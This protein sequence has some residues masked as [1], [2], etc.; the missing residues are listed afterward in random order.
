MALLEREKVRPPGARKAAILMLALGPED[1][2]ELLAGLDPAEVEEISSEMT[3]LK[4]APAELRTSVLN[5]F[6]SEVEATRYVPEP[7]LSYLRRLLERSLG[8]EDARAALDRVEE[9]LSR[10][11]FRFLHEADPATIVNLLREEH[12]QTCALILCHLPPE[13]AAKC[14]EGLPEEKRVEV[15]ARAGRMQPTSHEAVRNVEKAVASRLKLASE[16]RVEESGGPEAVARILNRAHRAVGSQVM[17]SLEE[18]D[19]EL[20]GRLK[21]MMFRFEDII[22]ADDR[23]IQ[24]L[25]K[26]IPP[27]ELALAL[28]T[29][30]DELK[31][32]F[33]RN[34]SERARIIVKEDMEYLGPVRLS[35]VEAAQAR[36]V[37][38][39]RRFEEQGDL[40]ILGRGAED[41]I[42]V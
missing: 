18:A 37:E 14:L 25:T 15:V 39:V 33:F 38:I 35:D 11:P 41:E 32:K 8:R 7:S 5:E 26:E 4:E 9:A 3:R 1:A 27:E 34:M 10:T 6:V 2:S 22:H 24:N 29:A 17:D 42:I 31:Q 20:A 16:A 23:G 21:D 40:I 13:L 28:K 12:P 30:S 19:S 36:I